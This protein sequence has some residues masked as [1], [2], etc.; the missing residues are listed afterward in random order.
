MR[1]TES[2]KLCYVKKRIARIFETKLLEQ[3]YY[4]PLDWA[5]V[6]NNFCLVYEDESK[7]KIRLLD[8]SRTLKDYGITKNYSEILFSHYK[9]F[10]GHSKARRYRY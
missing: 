2:M 3:N 5:R 8:D 4:N 7:E 6:W 1:V 9:K 10:T